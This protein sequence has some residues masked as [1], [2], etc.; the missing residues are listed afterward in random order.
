MRRLVFLAP[1]AQ[2]VQSVVA[3]FIAMGIEKESIHT[4]ADDA[5]RLEKLHF[6]PATVVETTE[7]E[8]DMDWGM[9]AGGGFGLAAGL[10]VTTALGPVGTVVTGGAVIASSLL[11]IGIGGW[12]GKMVGE[13]TPLHLLEKYKHALEQGC[14]LVMVDIPAERMSEVHK[15][16]RQHCPKA[17]VEI[18]YL[19]WD[20]QQAA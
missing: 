4:I 17:L 16:I 5:S 3:D 10:M 12:L 15:V 11:G 18:I 19:H 8:N 13:E 9:V 6:R 14:F 20:H 7:L 2:Q 1:Q